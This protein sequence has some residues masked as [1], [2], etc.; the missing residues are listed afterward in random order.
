MRA[1]LHIPED[2][3][4]GFTAAGFEEGEPGE[5]TVIA[6]GAVPADWP[7]TL[8][9]L[10]EIFT[11]ARAAAVAGS[12]LVFVVSADA[13]LGRTGPTEAM[14]A[15]G[16]VSAARSL[17][18]ELRKEGVP[19]NCLAAGSDSPVG[20]VAEWARILLGCGPAD[21]TGELIQLGGVQIGKALA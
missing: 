14:A 13:L 6:A 10:T 17:A 16:I 11:A 8:D 19:V 3:R 5:P 4:R 21:P 2:L 7:G 15:T 1:H 9:R 20:T 18:A 12:P